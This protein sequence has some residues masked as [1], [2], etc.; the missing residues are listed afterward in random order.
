MTYLKVL[1]AIL[2]FKSFDLLAT[3][4]VAVDA[5]LLGYAILFGV[6]VCVWALLWHEF[7]RTR[8]PMDPK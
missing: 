6:W 1:F 3:R 5:G 7:A 2:M 4:G 8:D